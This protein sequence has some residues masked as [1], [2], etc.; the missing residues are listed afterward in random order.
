MILLLHFFWVGFGRYSWWY[1]ISQEGKGRIIREG[2][3]NRRN[4]VSLFGV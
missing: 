4:M 1:R 2:L 3:G